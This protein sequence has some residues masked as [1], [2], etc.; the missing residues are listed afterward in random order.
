M[1]KKEN[2][3]LNLISWITGIIV[4]LALGFA[5][6][7]G[8]L[9]LPVWLGGHILAAIAGWILVIT[10]FVSVILTIIK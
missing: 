7:G 3:L 1:A 4:S 10:T 6:I 8:T 9:S 5:M 2:K